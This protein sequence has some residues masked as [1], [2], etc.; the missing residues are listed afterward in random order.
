MIDGGMFPHLGMQ[1][2][3]GNR[4]EEH[5]QSNWTKFECSVLFA[6]KPSLSGSAQ[7]PEYIQKN[8]QE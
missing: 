2:H 8:G 5:S 6:I 1:I 7:R 3:K 4:K